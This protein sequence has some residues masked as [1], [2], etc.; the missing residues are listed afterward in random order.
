[1]SKFAPLFA[2]CGART[3]GGVPG[4]NVRETSTAVAQQTD[5]TA[6]LSAPDMATSIPAPRSRDGK[7][8]RVQLSR[9]RYGR[10]LCLT[11]LIG[12]SAEGKALISSIQKIEQDRFY[13][14]HNFWR[15]CLQLL[16]KSRELS[17][18]H[19]GRNFRLKN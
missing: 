2:R 5:C 18:S 12:V 10:R 19:R 9:A 15:P 13:F 8:S 17:A 3:S 16:L 6:G 4:D 14:A 7:E 1:M 11:L